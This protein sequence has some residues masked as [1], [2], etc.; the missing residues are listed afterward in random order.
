MGIKAHESSL[1]EVIAVLRILRVPIAISIAAFIVFFAPDQIRE[2]YRIISADRNFFEAFL[3]LISIVVLTLVLWATSFELAVKCG[4]PAKSGAAGL[5][6]T[7]LPPALA[8]LPLVG[9]ALGHLRARTL[10]Y[11]DTIRGQIDFIGSPWEALDKK[12]AHALNNELIVV[13]VA[14]SLLS[15]TLFVGFIRAQRARLAES[16]EGRRETSLQKVLFSARG[17]IYAALAVFTLALIV[18]WLSPKAIGYVGT[19]PLISIFFVCLIVLLSQWSYQQMATGVPILLTITGLAIIFSLFDLNDNHQ[20]LT[21]ETAPSRDPKTVGA[22][23]QAW[24]DSRPD[25]DDYPDGY[26]VYVVAAQ[27]G[28]IYAAYHTATFLARLQD[29]CPSFKNHVFAISAVSGGSLGA[30]I[31]SSQMA[32]DGAPAAGAAPSKPC[33]PLERIWQTQ[34]FQDSIRPRIIEASHEDRAAGILKDDLLAPLV[35][36]TLFPD[37]IQR[38][39]FFKV[40]PFDRA[41]GLEASFIASW[42]GQY[43]EAANPFEKD[44]LTSWDSKGSAPA[45]LLNT[46]ES[47]SGRRRVIAPFLIE[48]AEKVA[49]RDLVHFP[50]W[51]L[52]LDYKPLVPEKQLAECKGLSISLA[53]AVGLSAR[54]PWVTPAGS[55]N[56]NCTF[57]KKDRKYRLVDG[58]Y[59]DNSGVVTAVDVIIE[60][61]KG[62]KANGIKADIHLIALTTGDYA[63][64]SAYGLGEL[65]EPLRSLVSSQSSRGKIA[66]ESAKEILGNSGSFPRVHEVSFR[67]PIY[68]VPLGWRLSTQTQDIIGLQNGRHWDCDPDLKFRQTSV[69]FSTAD[70]VQLLIFHQLNKTVGE[71]AHQASI[72]NAW[73]EKHPPQL[74][75][76]EPPKVDADSLITCFRDNAILKNT[77]HQ[78][79]SAQIR[80]LK[81]LVQTW[82]QWAALTDERWL[83]YAIAVMRYESLGIPGR[84]YNCL[85]E[86]CVIEKFKGRYGNSTERPFYVDWALKPQ[87]NGNRYYE[88]GL[89]RLT[90]PESYQTVG[91]LI[92]EDL[93]GNPDLLLLPEVSSRALLA[94]LTD[95]RAGSRSV[96]E[97]INDKN[98]DIE[99]LVV[100]WKQG[101]SFIG[102]WQSS[103]L[104]AREKRG[105]SG[106]I[107]NITDGTNE[108]MACMQKGK[109][110]LKA[111]EPK[112]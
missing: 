28:G 46:T 24:Y 83:A 66:V 58:G 35:S 45:L 41:R 56:T 100:M 44:Y 105:I 109:A 23:F 16:S 53:T 70:C 65:L 6:L 67:N 37:A 68:T 80:A 104:G 85:T 112:S 48:S 77:E 78:L 30:A 91:D 15:I 54:F 69:A 97:F 96:N 47:D 39:L 2:L 92:G 63:Q 93:Y 36:R 57:D 95:P 19:L 62:I 59:S 43:P 7:Y 1:Q 32:A 99:S 27:G 25:K 29:Y 82:N 111:I 18:L 12:V 3:S 90:A 14:I 84:A 42:R 17:L 107:R 51:G 22:E 86:Q 88:R 8:V 55:V 74:N 9:C 72:A 98:F 26:P 79:N 21:T 108:A 60:I 40:P 81:A 94:Y 31:F 33:A 101:P 4:L 110:N 38:L 89:L 76:S 102:K 10:Q 52:N 61:E 13:A 5:V 20:V 11:D 71:A 87:A 50:L 103:R 75:L 34:R 73:R 64:R 49:P 106:A